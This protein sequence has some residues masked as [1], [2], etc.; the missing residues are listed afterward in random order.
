MFR[1]SMVTC[2]PFPCVSGR[3]VQRGHRHEIHGD[4]GN[5]HEAADD[6][7]VLVISQRKYRSK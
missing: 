4:A 1:C 7:M 2:L 5:E 3:P 6:F